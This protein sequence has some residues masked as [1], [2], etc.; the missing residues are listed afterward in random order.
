MDNIGTV[1]MT[2]KTASKP[3]KAAALESK[4]RSPGVTRRARRVGCSANGT[5]PAE[6]DDDYQC[7]KQVAG[8][9]QD[10]Q[11]KP[12]CESRGKQELGVETRSN[13]GSQ[14]TDLLTDA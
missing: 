10:N 2:W 3:D 4:A 13:I 11:G 12:L 7:R 6:S 9:R 1:P 14:C 5:V 8:S